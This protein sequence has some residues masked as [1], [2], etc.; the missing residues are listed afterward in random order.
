MT[1]PFISR[2]PWR[3]ETWK[4]HENAEGVRRSIR[5]AKTHGRDLRIWGRIDVGDPNDVD[6]YE[7]PEAEWG[8][9]FLKE[10]ATGSWPEG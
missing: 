3:R 1:D 6:Y 4:G 7:I 9:V 10:G 5:Y 8:D 2:M